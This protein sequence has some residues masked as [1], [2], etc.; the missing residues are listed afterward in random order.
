VVELA[1]GGK[2]WVTAT[3]RAPK[4]GS[5]QRRIAALEAGAEESGVGYELFVRKDVNAILFDNWSLLS[6]RM[7]CAD[8]ERFDCSREQTLLYAALKNSPGITLE[9]LLG[10]DNVDEARMLSSLGHA[11]MG[12]VATADLDKALL[13]LATKIWH[14]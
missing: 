11:L 1:G 7:N 9:A 10:L 2:R 5:E 12:G 3:S 6:A 13:S 4:T 8:L 14:N